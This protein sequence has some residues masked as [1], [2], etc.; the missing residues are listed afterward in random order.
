MYELVYSGCV[1]I[2]VILEVRGCRCLTLNLGPIF[3]L[4]L[5]ASELSQSSSLYPTPAL[6]CSRCVCERG[7]TWLFTRVLGI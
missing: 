5:L 4:G 2:S 1:A 6:G 3:Q 7:H